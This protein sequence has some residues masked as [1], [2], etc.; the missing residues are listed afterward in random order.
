M[1]F[2]TYFIIV[3]PIQSLER[4]V[5]DNLIDYVRE[6]SSKHQFGF[7]PNR[8]TLQQLLTFANKVLESRHEADVVYMD[9]KTAF[10]FACVPQS[11]A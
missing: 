3:Y 4:I 7:F 11:S 1:A 6:R 2:Q 5:Y 9:F 10:D 8:S